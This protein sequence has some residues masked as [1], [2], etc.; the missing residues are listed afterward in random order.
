MLREPIDLEEELIDDGIFNIVLQ[1]TFV[2]FVFSIAKFLAAF[3]Y[4]LVKYL[5]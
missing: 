3:Y 4:N 5:V 2:V 1:C